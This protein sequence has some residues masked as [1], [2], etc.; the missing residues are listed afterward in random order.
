MS[1][2][3]SQRSDVINDFDKNCVKQK[4]VTLDH[5]TIEQMTI[6]MTLD[7]IKKGRYNFAAVIFNDAAH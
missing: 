2:R 6:M 1:S 4:S 3:S 7:V 5:H